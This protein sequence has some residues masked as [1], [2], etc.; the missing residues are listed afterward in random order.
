MTAR[1]M[2]SPL[3][4]SKPWYRQRWPWLLMAGPAIVVVAGLVT[5]WIAVTTDDGL[6][7]QDYYKRG[8]LINKD[9]ESADRAIALNLGASLR[10]A[11][12]GSVDLEMTGLPG[13]SSAPG[14]IAVT[15]GRAAR[16]GQDVVTALPRTAGGRYA[17]RVAPLTAGRWRVT[18]E[19]GDWRL[20]TAAAIS[21]P[22]EIRLG[23]ARAV[24]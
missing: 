5:A 3:H 8:L 20:A 18:L 22:G 7:S 10:V 23:S 19:G 24:D 9:L 6:V 15:F 14:Q 4:P 1:A 17:G 2:P 13:G 12:D 11:P 16:S 21:L